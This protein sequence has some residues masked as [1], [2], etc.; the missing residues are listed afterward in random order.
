MKDK[1][2]A[3]WECPSHTGMVGAHESEDRFVALPCLPLDIQRTSFLPTPAVNSWAKNPEGLLEP[4]A[5][6]SLGPY[7]EEVV[8]PLA[9][10][11]HFPW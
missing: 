8:F 9:G 1:R 6:M 3:T 5:S 4:G 10:Q 7:P 11:P 2:S